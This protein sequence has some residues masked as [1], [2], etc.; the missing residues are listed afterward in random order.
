MALNNRALFRLSIVSLFIFE[1]ALHYIALQFSDNEAINAA[2][3]MLPEGFE[4]SA[5]LEQFS[6]VIISVAVMALGLFV[7]TGGLIGVLCFQPWGRWLYLL[8]SIYILGVTTIVGPSIYFGWEDALCS[9]ASMAEGA[10]ILAM[11]LPPINDEFRK[12]S[13]HPS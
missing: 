2:R 13:K 9:I 6:N 12:S 5:Y 8:S 10:I 7:I 1:L 4:G 11:F 3:K